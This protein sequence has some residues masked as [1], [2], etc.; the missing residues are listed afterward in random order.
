MTNCSH[1]KW[2]KTLLAKCVY[3]SVPKIS[4]I[5]LSSFVWAINSK[6]S[7]NVYKNY[8]F[9]FSVYHNI[10]SMASFNS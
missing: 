8:S 3:E 9:I 10:N 5:L 1:I 6:V 7:F 4:S 2:T